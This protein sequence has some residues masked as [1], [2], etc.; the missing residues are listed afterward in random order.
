MKI[1]ILKLS[2]LMSPRNGRCFEYF[3]QH[4][5]R[6]E[7]R[8]NQSAAKFKPPVYYIGKLL[9]F[10]R[11][12]DLSF[13]RS[14]IIIAA[15]IV[16]SPRISRA[17]ISARA[18]EKTFSTNDRRVT[19]WGMSRK[20]WDSMNAK[21]PPPIHTVEASRHS[22]Q[23]FSWKGGKLG[24]LNYTFLA[25]EDESRKLLKGHRRRRG[26]EITRYCKKLFLHEMRCMIIDIIDS[27]CGKYVNSAISSSITVSVIIIN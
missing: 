2:P 13:S 8:V 22:N 24:H 17:S 12:F 3:E 1:R 9:P 14:R 15:S 20:S 27:I 25:D 10:S 26:G 21:D 7:I 5:R 6:I 16:E 19:S 23:W 11:E 4:S 18:H